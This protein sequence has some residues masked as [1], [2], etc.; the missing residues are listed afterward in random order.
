M[1]ILLID[2]CAE[3]SCKNGDVSTERRIEDQYQDL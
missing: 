2:T 3:E 1:D